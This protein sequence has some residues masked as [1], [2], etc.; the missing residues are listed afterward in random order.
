MNIERSLELAWHRI[1]NGQIDDAID[2][3]RQLLS[4]EPDLPEAHAYLGLCLLSK[5]RLGA[6]EQ[7]A[8]IALT[9]E[10]GLELAHYALASIHMGQRRFS[11]AQPHVRQL[12]DMDPNHAP[13]YLL[14]AQLSRLTR[15][16]A[17]VLP[18][19]RKALE[20]DPESSQVLADLSEYHADKGELELAEGYARESLRFEP[21]NVEGLV[22]MGK[23]MLLGEDIG[24]ARDHAVWA[25]RLEPD[26][27]SALGLMAS[28]KAREN[29]VLGL[30][31]RY[32][33]WMNRIGS[34][35][36]ILVLLFAYI[37]YRAITMGL[38][39][40]GQMGAASIVKFTW[41]GVVIYTFVGPTLFDKML[42][43]ELGSVKLSSDF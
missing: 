26:S 22:A 18:A 33:V 37:L 32:N 41:L 7:E 27:Q 2:A 14:D 28:I 21:E 10:P 1:Q 13:Y 23:V 30:W 25:L 16:T 38:V 12:L 3:L 6:A 36:A 5:R 19:L 15:R 11:E 42:R 31:W 20:L 9:M 43:K 34:T 39:D 17:K 8:K 40:F 29:P 24:G 4:N 35:R